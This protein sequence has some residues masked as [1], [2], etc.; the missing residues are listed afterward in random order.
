MS[1]YLYCQTEN[2]FKILFFYAYF[3]LSTK[4]K[5]IIGGKYKDFFKMLL[6]LREFW[7]FGNFII[8]ERFQLENVHIRSAYVS[9][10]QTFHVEQLLSSLGY[11]YLKN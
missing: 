6:S 5:K 3:E 11:I 4:N 10:T 9:S 8:S 1:F 2:N 7:G